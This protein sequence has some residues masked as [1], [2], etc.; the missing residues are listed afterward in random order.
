MVRRNVVINIPQPHGTNGSQV[1]LATQ[2]VRHNSSACNEAKAGWKTAKSFRT[3]TTL[4]ANLQSN[5][6]V[7]KKKE[8][9]GILSKNIGTGGAGQPGIL[10]SKSFP[11][12]KSGEF[13]SATC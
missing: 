8:R 12:G 4:R 1:P 5:R 10:I 6:W 9:M 3:D 11:L 2:P 13:F 7:A